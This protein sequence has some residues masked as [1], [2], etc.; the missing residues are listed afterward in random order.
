L[1]SHELD[2]KDVWGAQTGGVQREV[3]VKYARLQAGVV[4]CKAGCERSMG[5][6]YVELSDQAGLDTI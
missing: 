6:P 5:G 1:Q 3:A 4:H 2:P